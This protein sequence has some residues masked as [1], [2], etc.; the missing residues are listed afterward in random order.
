M[1]SPSFSYDTTADVRLSD[2]V[3]QALAWVRRNLLWLALGTLAG[4][5]ISLLLNQTSPK[6]YTSSFIGYANNMDDLR[7]R[8]SIQHLNLLRVTNDLPE[9]A[10]R[11]GLTEAEAG[12]VNSI[13][14]LT[15]NTLEADLPTF[16]PREPKTF[17]FSIQATVTNPELFPKLE[18]GIVRYIDQMPIIQRLLADQRASYR[19]RIAQDEQEIAYLESVKKHLF[20]N[21]G[22][23]QVL[24]IGTVSRHIVDINDKLEENRL[25]LTKLEHE[26]VITRPME[27]VRKPSSP[28][29]YRAS[30]SGA[31][32]GLALTLA[33]LGL[34]AL[35]RMSR[36][37][38][39]K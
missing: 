2:L 13:A 27:I 36:T 34:M 3:S 25:S 15:N 11:L 23:M 16:P 4:A 12:Q 24:D 5:G 20:E 14:G 28:G 30:A 29:M 39:A 1:P 26:V 35:V 9:L 37:P 21:A 8:E 32:L 7:V 17:F 38:E 31:A 18:A 22:K 19:R 6:Q 10:R 33:I